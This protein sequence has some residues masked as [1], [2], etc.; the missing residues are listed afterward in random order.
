MADGV[1]GPTASE[2]IR[3]NPAWSS[4]TFEGNARSWRDANA[5]FDFSASDLVPREVSFLLPR[6]FTTI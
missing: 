1:S 2:Q 6:E 5:T 3:E 4:G